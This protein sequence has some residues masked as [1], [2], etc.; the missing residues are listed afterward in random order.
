MR[1]FGVGK[2]SIER[3]IEDETAYVMRDMEASHGK[4]FD[5]KYAFQKSTCNIICTVLFGNR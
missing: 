5:P 3:R 4:P 2:A 1:N